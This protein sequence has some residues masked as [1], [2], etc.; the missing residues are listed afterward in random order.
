M[1]RHP[2]RKQESPYLSNANR[3][4]D[5]IAAIQVL[6]TYKFYKLDFDAWANRISG[7]RSHAGHWQAVFEQHPEFFRLDSSRKKASLVWRRQHRKLYDVDQ[8]REISQ[9]RYESLSAEH[10]ARV[11][12]TPLEPDEI[13]ALIGTA[14]SLHGQQLESRKDNRW[15]VTAL[16]GLLGVTI[17]GALAAFTQ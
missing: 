13:T 11:S 12:R 2:Q 15:L 5:V 14:I 9:A 10:K 17:G 1:T 8:S 3:L 7:D 4:A 16:F 6:A